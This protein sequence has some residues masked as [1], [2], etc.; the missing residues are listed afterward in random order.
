MV[1]AIADVDRA[2]LNEN[3]VRA[4]E[5]AAKRVTVWAVAALAGTSHCG[6][7]P[8][9]QVD[10]ANHM[11]FRIGN[12]E[13]L[14]GCIGDALRT[15][16]RTAGGAELRRNGGTAIACIA[17]LASP[18]DVCE[19]GMCRID[20]E[21]FVSFAKNQIHGA[22]GRN[23]YR[24]RTSRRRPGE[25]RL[26]G[27]RRGLTCARKGR[28]Y[29]SLR[30]DAPHTMIHDVADVNIV[31]PIQSDAV[32]LRESRLVCRSTIATI[33]ADA[34]SGCRTDQTRFHVDVSDDMAVSLGNV[35]I[36]L[37]VET[38]FV[39]S[40]E[41]S[42]FRRGAIAGMAFH[43]IAGDDGNR[44]C[45]NFEAKNAIAAEVCPVKSAIRSDHE[46]KRIVDRRTIG[47]LAFGCQSRFARARKSG[48]THSRSLRENRYRCC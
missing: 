47:R 26:L 15:I 14:V 12:V 33:A 16:Q 3:T 7:C 44:L 21:H 46:S 36:P 38:N 8:L 9:T 45:A 5:F 37:A 13:A 20:A 1:F 17:Q 42:C 4:S 6:H 11:I 48:Y 41:L 35:D 27:R 18:G 32:R 25:W 31:R 34:C 2:S 43:T 24:T 28:D 30:I 23:V 10:A 19:T 29:S 40:A 22:I 39:W